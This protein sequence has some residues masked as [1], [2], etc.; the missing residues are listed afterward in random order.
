MAAGTVICLVRSWDVTRSADFASS[1]AGAEKLGTCPRLKSKTSPFERL[2]E[3]NSV[4]TRYVAQPNTAK[5]KRTPRFL[6]YVNGRHNRHLETSPPKM[7]AVV[8]ESGIE[9]EFTVKQ[10]SARKSTV[11]RTYALIRVEIGIA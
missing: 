7:G 4:A 2:A 3:M 9:I 8:I 11:S 5:A 1:S 6:L 10:V